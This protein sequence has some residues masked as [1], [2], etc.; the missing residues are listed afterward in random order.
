MRVGQFC[1]VIEDQIHVFRIGGNVAKSASLTFGNF[2]NDH[3]GVDGVEDFLGL[4]RYGQNQFAQRQGQVR[5]CGSTV[6]EEMEELG[7]RFS[8]AINASASP[9]RT[10][11]GWITEA[12]KP[13][14][15]QT[16]DEE[17]AFMARAS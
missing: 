17:S 10:M 9:G 11:P 12:Y 16:S 5:Y 4:G 15:P 2:E 7:A 1:A 8:H 13:L 6:R 14:R 3:L